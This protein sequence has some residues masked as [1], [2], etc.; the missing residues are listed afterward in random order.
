M[1]LIVTDKKKRKYVCLVWYSKVS[2][3]YYTILSTRMS[4]DTPEMVTDY[5]SQNH[6]RSDDRSF[7]NLAQPPV[8]THTKP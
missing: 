3:M 5:V 1:R 6:M 2:G 7:I 4:S 8:Q